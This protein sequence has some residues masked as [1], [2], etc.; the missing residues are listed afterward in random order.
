MKQITLYR[1]LSFILL[2]IAAVL[3]LLTVIMLFVALANPPLLLA[4]FLFASVVIYIITSFIFLQK[5]IE[6]KRLCNHSLK[7]W[8]KV[9]AIVSVVFCML[10]LMQSVA[11]LSD[12]SLLAEALKQAMAQ[13]KDLMVLPSATYMKIMKGILYFFLIF[14]GLLLVHIIFTFKVLKAYGSMFRLK[15]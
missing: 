15:Q 7:E 11:L 13:Q 6:Q 4:V 2:P 1:I 3:G 9:N 14:S 5:G 8:I 10:F 12:A